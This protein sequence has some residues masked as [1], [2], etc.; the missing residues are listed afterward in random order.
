MKLFFRSILFCFLL[1]YSGHA[2]AAMTSGTVTAGSI[3]AGG[4]QTQTFSGTAGD[5]VMLSANASYNVKI[6]V[7]KPDG[8]LLTSGPNR[9]TITSPGLP[10]TGTYSVVI[11]GELGTDAG[12]YNLYY[13]E[14][15][16]AVSSGS[17][18][19]GSTATGS[20][21]VNG[22]ISYQF[23]GTAGATAMLSVEGSGYT[24]D[25]WV[26]N[27]D[28]TFNTDASNRVTVTEA[29]TGTYTVV[30]RGHNITDSGSYSLYF[31]Q[32]GGSVSSG[33]LTSGS[34][35]TTGSMPVNGL[36]SYQFSG[37]AGQ[38]AFISMPASGYTGHIY[39]YNPDGSPAT[40][41]TDRVFIS[42]LAATGTY[43]VVLQ[44]ALT[45][46][47]G[48]YTIY[49]VIGAG[50]VSNG[51]LTNG[52]ISP[53]TQGANQLISYQLAGIA[54]QGV[55]L[56]TSSS[57]NYTVY[58]LNTNGDFETDGTNAAVV[59][60]LPNTGTYTVVLWPALA[61]NAGPY[62]IYWTGSL[63]PA[64]EADGAV[65][66]ISTPPSPA[67]TS[68]QLG[69]G[70]QA[71]VSKIG[72]ANVGEPI[73]PATGNVTQLVTDYTTKGTNPLQLIRYYNSMTVSR[74]ATIFTTML[75]IN[76]RTN[77]SA[78]LYIPA[79]G[80]GV[81]AQ[82][83]N[84]QVVNFYPNGTSWI[85]DGDMDYTLTHVGATWTLTGPDDTVET[86]TASGVEATLNSIKLR[87][88]YTQTLHYTSNQLLSVTD[89]YGR[90]ISFTYT[91]AVA[92][93]VTTPDGLNLTYGYTTIGTNKLLTTVTYN[94]SPAT[95]LTYV[96]GN[97]SFPYAITGITDENGHSYAS[98]AYDASGRGVSS[99]LSGGVNFT[100]V[101]YFSDHSNV[102]GPQGI[103]ETYK[104]STI[105][106]LPKLT[107]IDR[108]ANGTVTAA[109]KTFAY[110][111]NG[112]MKSITDWN[113]D[114]TAYTNN[115]N[116]NP[117]QIVFASGSAVTHTTTISYDATWARL[118]HVITE[119]GLTTTINYSS[120]NGTPLTRVEA[121]TTQPVDSVLHQRPVPHLD[122][123]LYLDGPAGD[124][125]A[126][127]HRRHRQNHLHLCRRRADQRSG[128]P[129]P[130]HQCGDL[131]A[132]WLAADH[133][134]PE[135]HA[136]HPR[137]QPAPVADLERDGLKLRQPH[138][139][140]DL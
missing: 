25:I 104:F 54:G 19:S 30:I 114:V 134:R 125:P 123:D 80:T 7:N 109:T 35:T 110:D 59:A 44:G 45:T 29:A 43:T 113:S 49:Y 33:S 73:N 32:G 118:A 111:A 108:A 47:S 72:L 137:L 68:C 57:Y 16:K 24:G 21:P 91:G 67:P 20:I 131:Q 81:T 121:D 82:R 112:Y 75:G 101:S 106:N 119:P 139:Q 77:F 122:D 38:M 124:L 42:S 130:Q 132:R 86:Y 18:T 50:G 40:N 9:V 65:P 63:P 74:G 126:A 11:S 3:V 6:T 31:V 98:W 8:T 76:W 60:S 53:G 100:S 78:Y 127:A 4:T 105:Q 117:T 87:N 97:G 37:T 93:G 52:T 56:T 26:F 140:P 79:A 27:P 70:S 55:N 85:P 61:S 120:S 116:G 135:P 28:G 107:E 88:G 10:V 69:E 71:Q 103:K 128:C 64:P 41:A 102:T 66:C 13:V 51:S 133:P 48:S 14:A 36:I 129:W 94:T 17:L 22:L 83:P 46:D 99:Q 1:F 34:T 92:T 58:F 136:D 90:H 62:S 12:S 15:T 5:S 115:A 84:G 96:Y 23:S 39:V 89:T 2:F 138:H 95:T